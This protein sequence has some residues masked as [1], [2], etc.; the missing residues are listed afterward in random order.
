MSDTELPDPP[1]DLS[2]V[3]VAIDHP[4]GECVVPLAEWLA[5]G[6]GPRPLVRPH[7]AWSRS[8]GRAVPLDLLPPLPPPP[9]AA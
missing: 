4:F 8:T 7:R 2:D 3:M 9:D 6:P 5:I 1:L